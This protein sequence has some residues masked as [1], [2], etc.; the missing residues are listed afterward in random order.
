M[1]ASPKYFFITAMIIVPLVGCV[2]VNMKPEQATKSEGYSFANPGNNFEEWKT[3]LADHAWKSTKTGNM[4]SVISE[5]SK[6]KDPSLTSIEGEALQALTDVKVLSTEEKI[7]SGRG[8]L[9][10]TV[11]GK[12]DGIRMKME[13]LSIKKNFCS[14]TFSYT[15]RDNQFE[16]EA[17]IFSQFLSGI[18]IQ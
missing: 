17:A 12:L 9:Q 6:K 4:I 16:Q 11:Q 8:A 5:C 18:S 15:G 14:Y 13:V 10:T 1:K 3:D 7:F 2:S